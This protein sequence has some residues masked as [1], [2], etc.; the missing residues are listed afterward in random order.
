MP[1]TSDYSQTVLLNV[2]KSSTEIGLLNGTSEIS[3]VSGYER[4]EIGG[5][6]TSI[7]G[8]IANKDIIFLFECSGGSATATHFGL[9]SGNTMMFYG[10]LS[11]ELPISEGY[12]P[13]IRARNLIIGLDKAA[14]ETYE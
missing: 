7:W 8:Q 4:K 9:F 11:P 3:G 5:I 12:V 13:L 14:L 1:F 10:A 6:D 2:I